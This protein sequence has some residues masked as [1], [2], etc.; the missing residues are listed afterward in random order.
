MTTLERKLLD[1]VRAC[2]VVLSGESMSKHTLTEALQLACDAMRAARESY[3]N[4][5]PTQHLKEPAP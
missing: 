4:E 5:V 2:A 1:A 3:P